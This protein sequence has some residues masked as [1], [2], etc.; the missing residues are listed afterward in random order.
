MGAGAAQQSIKV[1]D[2]A[3]YSGQRGFTGGRMAVERRTVGKIAERIVMNEFENQGFRATDLNKDGL[4]PNADLLV[5]KNGVAWQVQVKGS[6]NK[7][8]EP[9]WVGYGYCDQEIID[10]RTR[11]IFNRRSDS[12]YHA[13]H[14]VLVA[15]RSPAEYRCMVLPVVEA[16]RAAQFNLDGYYRLPRVRDGGARKPGKIWVRLDQ[17][18]KLSPR[19][20]R[21]DIERKLLLRWENCWS[22]DRAD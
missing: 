3:G 16:E 15:V 6:A 12:F 8:D 22:L 4:S 1:R 17:A 11:T 20:E 5:A 9:W 13:S 10:D 2:V 21:M 14:V 18:K 7:P 19:E